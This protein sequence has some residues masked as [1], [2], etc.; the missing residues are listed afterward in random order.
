MTEEFPTTSPPSQSKSVP[1]PPPTVR[2]EGMVGALFLFSLLGGEFPCKHERSKSIGGRL[3]QSS[4]SR[5]RKTR[6]RLCGTPNH[7]ASRTAH[8]TSPRGPRATPVFCH[9]VFGTANSA[10]TISP[11][12]AAKSR[13]ELEENSPGTFSAM[14]HRVPQSSRQ[15]STIRIASKKSPLLAPFKPARLPATLKS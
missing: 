13:P 6:R 5:T 1:R 7:C 11:T 4:E 8:S 12:T 14:V 9:F 2:R 3:L 15:I 10:P